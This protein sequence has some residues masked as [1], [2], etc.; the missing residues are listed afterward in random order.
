MVTSVSSLT[1]ARMVATSM[2]SH[3]SMPSSRTTPT[4]SGRSA[5]TI[6]A[7]SAVVMP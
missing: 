5:F 3:V 2:L 4:L 1:T 6:A 7:S